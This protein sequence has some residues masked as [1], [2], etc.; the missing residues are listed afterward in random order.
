MGKQLITVV[1]SSTCSAGTRRRMGGGIGRPGMSK[2]AWQTKRS[3]C[4]A[5]QPGRLGRTLEDRVT[6]RSMPF[7]ST[8]KRTLPQ[9]TKF[10]R[11]R[12]DDRMGGLGSHIGLGRY[13]K[14]LRS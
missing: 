12:S 2:Q 7:R 13:V 8:W 4:W 10:S 14:T 11:T 3:A 9:V 1:L 6:I 5:G